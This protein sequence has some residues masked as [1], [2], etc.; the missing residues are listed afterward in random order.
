MAA[1]G[2]FDNNNVFTQLCKAMGDVY[3]RESDGKSLRGI[4]Y[5]QAFDDFVTMATMTS[6]V[7][8]VEEHNA[9][10]DS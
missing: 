4:R 7:I 2:A 10:F 5:G 9:V 8:F 1:D 3:L 6:L